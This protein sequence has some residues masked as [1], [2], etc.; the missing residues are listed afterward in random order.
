M[1]DSEDLVSRNT[2]QRPPPP[3]VYRRLDQGVG[4]RTKGGQRSEH[5]ERSKG[6]NDPD[7]PRIKPVLSKAEV[8]E[9]SCEL[10]MVSGTLKSM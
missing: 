8:N 2:Q 7:N 6:R 10:T 1:A 5:E 3:N 4:S 9:I